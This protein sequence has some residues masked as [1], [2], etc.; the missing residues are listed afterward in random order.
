MRTEGTTIQTYSDARSEQQLAV[1]SAQRAPFY[2][3]LNEVQGKIV[4]DY[5]MFPLQ[6]NGDFL[7]S[8]WKQSFIIV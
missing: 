5:P 2:Q 7:V 1:V 4:E 6:K 3:R 8:D